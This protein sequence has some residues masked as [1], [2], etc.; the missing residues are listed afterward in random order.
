M[1]ATPSQTTGLKTRPTAQPPT[2]SAMSQASRRTPV[3]PA[4]SGSRLQASALVPARRPAPAPH[5]RGHHQS[6]ERHH[7]PECL[8]GRAVEATHGSILR[9][10]WLPRPPS[11]VTRG[12]GRC[13]RCVRRANRPRA[14]RSHG[15]GRSGDALDPRHRLRRRRRPVAPSTWPRALAA[16]DV[17]PDGRARRGAR[18]A[19]ARPPAGPGRRRARRGRA[20]RGRAGARQ[21]QSTWPR[22]C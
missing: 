14:L 15:V 11:A 7:E 9:R 3:S 4:A 12:Y 10:L 2:E 17:D 16:Y 22:C 20:R 8:P 21:D 19:P 6:Q 18:G 5:Q 1:T 13:T